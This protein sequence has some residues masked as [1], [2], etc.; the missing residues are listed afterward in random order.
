MSRVLRK[1]RVDEISTCKAGANNGLSRIT[2]TKNH[3]GA[4]MS[5]MT[6]EV[7][8][9]VC[10]SDAVSK[11]QLSKLISDMAASQR[12]HDQTPEQAFTKFICEDELGKSLFKI[13]QSARG[14]R[15]YFQEMAFQKHS[16]SGEEDPPGEDQDIR[17]HQSPH[18]R[19]LIKM[20]EE[21]RQTPEGK[22]MSAAQSFT[23]CATAT[24]EGRKLLAADKAWHQNCADS[25]R[26][27]AAA[28]I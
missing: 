27:Q 20:S 10:A 6:A 7:L 25:M 13:L 24:D 15:D 5:G 1:I 8:K 12:K 21:F 18:Y 23:H 17:T 3:E 11:V 28:G 14:G 4:D 26:A 19:A 22:A 2:F 9:R 16:R